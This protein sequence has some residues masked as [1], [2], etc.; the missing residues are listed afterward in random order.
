MPLTLR[1]ATCG[2]VITRRLEPTTELLP[3]GDRE[4][5][6]PGFRIVEV[7]PEFDVWSTAPVGDWLVNKED[8]LG[9]LEGGVRNGCCGVD[10]LDGPN[11]LCPNGHFVA[12]E[13]GDC[14][15][16][17]FAV[18]HRD[19]VTADEGADAKA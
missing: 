13:V 19:R 7:D 17:T 5:L 11:L 4:P 2:V 9:C 12:T 6:V 16:S 8:L 15:T 3:G 1:C 18:V 10:G 14:W